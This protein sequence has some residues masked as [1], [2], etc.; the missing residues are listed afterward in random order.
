MIKQV[1]LKELFTKTAK[2]KK[3]LQV[4]HGTHAYLLCLSGHGIALVNVHLHSECY[5]CSPV[6]YTLYTSD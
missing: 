4:K 5:F 1:N 6:C 2:E 3:N